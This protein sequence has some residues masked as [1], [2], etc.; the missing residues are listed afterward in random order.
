MPYQKPGFDCSSC[1]MFHEFTPAQLSAMRAM[2]VV[3]QCGKCGAE[4]GLSR[5]QDFNVRVRILSMRKQMNLLTLAADNTP[6][7]PTKCDSA[8]WINDGLPDLPAIKQIKAQAEIALGLPTLPALP[9]I[10]LTSVQQQAKAAILAQDATY[11]PIDIVA[12]I[13]MPPPLPVITRDPDE[14]APVATPAP[15]GTPREL[16]T[17]WYDFQRFMPAHDGWFHC[18]LHNGQESPANLWFD[19]ASESFHEDESKQMRIAGTAITHFRGMV[20]RCG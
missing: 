1:Q 4:H 5:A 3:H 7:E 17:N 18:K 15:A 13:V 2:E 9:A 6:D 20:Q 8:G 10:A 14:T 12:T 11:V 19:R 16:L